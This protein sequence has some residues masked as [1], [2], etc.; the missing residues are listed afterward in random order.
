MTRWTY[1]ED[2]LRVAF[3]I[4]FGRLVKAVVTPTPLCG[5]NPSLGWVFKEV[6]P[7]SG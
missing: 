6:C 1:L 3:W 5:M 7:T 2:A 4:Q